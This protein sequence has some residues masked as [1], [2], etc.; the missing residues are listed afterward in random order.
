MGAPETAAE[1]AEKTCSTTLAPPSEKALACLRLLAG[2]YVWW[3]TPAEAMQYP[4]RVAAQVMN[5]G[6][7]EDLTVMAE[8]VGEDYLREVLRHAEA[9][10]L[11]ARSW[12]YWHYRLGLAEFGVKPVPPMPGRKTA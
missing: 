2:T 4:D 8:A 12:H 7:W 10:Q 9:G 5:L 1:T 6:T 3:K 11:D